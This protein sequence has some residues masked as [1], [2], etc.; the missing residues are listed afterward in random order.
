[1]EMHIYSTDYCQGGA[2]GGIVSMPVFLGPSMPRFH[3]NVTRG[4]ESAVLER[5]HHPP[6]DL[7]LCK[8]LPFHFYV[9]STTSDFD[10]AHYLV[11]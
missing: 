10:A 4:Q 8:I 1:M 6:L 11:R 3:I 2:F 5:P 7:R 9:P